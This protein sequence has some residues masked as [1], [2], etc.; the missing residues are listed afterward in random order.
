MTKKKK[1]KK[2]LMCKCQKGFSGFIC[3][4]V[5]N[6]PY[7]EK[8]LS[9]YFEVAT[10]LLLIIIFFFFFRTGRRIRDVLLGVVEG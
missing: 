5:A 1:K 4:L 7:F 8:Q 6:S 9:P 10:L 3:F 2:K